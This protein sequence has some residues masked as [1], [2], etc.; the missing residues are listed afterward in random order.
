MALGGSTNAVLHL[1]AIAHAAEVPL[2]LDDFEAI[3]ARVP[4]LCDLKPSGRYVATDLHRVGGVPRGDED[5]A[6]A[7]PPARRLPHRHRDARSPRTSRPSPR[8]RPR[9]GR[10]PP[11]AHAALRGGPPGVLRGNLAPEGAVAKIS[12]VKTPVMRGP[13][14]VFESRGV[15]PRGDPRGP[16]APGDVI[17][18]R[19]EGPDRRARHARDARADVGDHRRGARAT[20]S[21]SS[22][23]AAS[24]AAP[25]AWWS[26]TWRRKPPWAVRS[27]WCRRATRSPS[28]RERRCCSST[29]TRPSSRAGAR[30]GRRPR[31]ATRAGVLAKYARLV[32]SAAQGAVTD[33][34]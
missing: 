19:Y 18:I 7:R 34:A 5:A 13:A 9:A 10:H 6:R 22:P 30:P 24:P 12:G 20:R 4:V 8:R 33:G 23:T 1:L 14:R 11:W 31:P 3:R 32:G 29:W 2:T 16:I 28:T 26:A 27:R 25:T 17:V 15:L 21:G